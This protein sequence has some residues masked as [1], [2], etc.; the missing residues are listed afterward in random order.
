MI[1]H[2]KSILLL[3]A[4]AFA[5][6]INTALVQAADK[7][8]E[9]EQAIQKVEQEWAAALVKGDQNLRIGR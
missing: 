6:S 1:M 9:D 3:V 4:L 7:N 8:S 2:K 5:F